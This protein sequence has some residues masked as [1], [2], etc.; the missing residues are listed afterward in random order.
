MATTGNKKG[1]SGMGTT[2]WD[3][4]SS[5][6]TQAGGNKT[7]GVA[8]T[9]R[10]TTYRQLDDQKARA[11]DTL[12]SIAG[13][14]R[15]MSQPLRDN[16]RSGLADYVNQAADG[17]E[18][19]ADDL[20]RQDVGNALR[21]AK[22]FAHR[23]PALFLGAAFTAGLLAARFLKSSSDDRDEGRYDRARGPRPMGTNDY[24]AN[25]YGTQSAQS[26]QYGTQSGDIPRLSSDRRPGE[27]I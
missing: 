26:G 10:D 16:G 2:N 23:Q 11:S 15:G 24:A 5:P 27:V 18:R 22:R 14:V 7:E 17:M 13:A 12:G 4:T 3:S 8:Q 9:L 19:W 1:S 20:K 6:G 25:P 21:A